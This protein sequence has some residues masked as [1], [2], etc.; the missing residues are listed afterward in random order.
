MLKILLVFYILLSPIYLAS[1]VEGNDFILL[2]WNGKDAIKA[3]QSGNFS[4][5]ERGDLYLGFKISNSLNP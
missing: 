2:G 1:Q 4:I 3:Y 5:I